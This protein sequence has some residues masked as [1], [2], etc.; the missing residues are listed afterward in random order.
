METTDFLRLDTRD[1]VDPT[2][3]SSVRQA[4]T[5][6]QEQYQTFMTDPLVKQTAPISEPIKKNKLSLLSR[7]SQREKSK[8][9]LQVSSL[10][11][12][13]SLLSRLYIAC[14]SRDGNLQDFYWT[15]KSGM[16]PTFIS[17]WQAQIGNQGR[18][19]GMPREQLYCSQRWSPKSWR[20][21]PR[22][23][24]GCQLFKPNATKIFDEYA[25]KIFLP[26][27]QGQLQHTSRADVKAQTREKRVS[28]E[29]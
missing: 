7:P 21:N 26:Y 14:Q 8:T 15:W 4:E 12:D 2:V 20:H 28:V 16:S 27:V 23:S 24:S 10:K 6:G 25:I 29:G 9:S 11:S 18:Y 19:F 17:A 5:M 22:W 1:I 13:C 3:A